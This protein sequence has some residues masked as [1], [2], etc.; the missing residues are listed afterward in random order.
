MVVPMSD[1]KDIAKHH[2]VR[3][4]GRRAPTE[5]EMARHVAKHGGEVSYTKKN[6]RIV[7]VHVAAPLSY[8][9]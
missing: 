8:P 3:F 2:I 1:K 5:A 6:G 4:R 9:S 7:D